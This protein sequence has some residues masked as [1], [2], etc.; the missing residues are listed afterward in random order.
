MIKNFSN[1]LFPLQLS[2][3][4]S[5]GPEFTTTI[6]ESVNG[7][8]SRCVARSV[9]IYRFDISY[10]ILSKEEREEL[11]NFYVA[12]M[13][14]AISFRFRDVNDNY[15]ECEQEVVNGRGEL[16]KSYLVGSQLVRRRIML[17]YN[18]KFFVDGAEV[19]A[20]VNELTG[21]FSIE[22]N[23]ACAT[24]TAKFNFDV[25]VRFDSDS[26]SLGSTHATSADISLVEVR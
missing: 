1:E 4:V 23:I 18:C 22:S 26:L 9:P 6:H 25:P 21:E 15:A 2:Y 7:R 16:Y 24:V 20:E 8:E 10:E 14:R 5:G 12:H 3:A 17:P 11:M 19:A 13:G